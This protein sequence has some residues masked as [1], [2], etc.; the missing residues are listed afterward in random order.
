[1]L[2]YDLRA[3][4]HYHRTQ[5]PDQ[6]G[7]WAYEGQ[8]FWLRGIHTSD[9]N[10]NALPAQQISKFPSR[11]GSWCTWRP[12][13]EKYPGL[14]LPLLAGWGGGDKLAIDKGGNLPEKVE[15]HWVRST[16][17]GQ[18]TAMHNIEWVMPWKQCMTTPWVVLKMDSRAYKFSFGTI[19]FVL[20]RMAMGPIVAMTTWLPTCSY[21]WSGTETK[22]SGGSAEEAALNFIMITF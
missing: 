3:V 2:H 18:M 6:N 4:A 5:C 19:T 10:G 1:M 16:L 15:N 8:H 9:R 21:S 13:P 20:E 12:T 17:N 7:H 14:H 11:F 22:H